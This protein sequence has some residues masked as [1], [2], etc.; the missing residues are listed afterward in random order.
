MNTYRNGDSINPPVEP[1]VE[2]P[3]L[4]TP[5]LQNIIQSIPPP[6]TPQNE[7]TYAQIQRHN[8]MNN[9]A[10]DF[11]L[12]TPQSRTEN[13]SVVSDYRSVSSNGY[14]SLP[15]PTP[16]GDVLRKNRPTSPETSF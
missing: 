5:L 6:L 10:L 15:Q 2:N 12:Q 16:N 3:T 9:D 13:G 4:Q 11:R 14:V 7:L 8:L 1:I